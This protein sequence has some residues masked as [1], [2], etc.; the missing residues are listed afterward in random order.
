MFKSIEAMS[1]ED[2]QCDCSCCVWPQCR[3]VG[4]DRGGQSEPATEEMVGGPGHAPF[5]YC[6]ESYLFRC[7]LKQRYGFVVG[8]NNDTVDFVCFTFIIVLEIVNNKKRLKYYVFSSVYLAPSS[9]TETKCNETS[10]AKERLRGDV[11][12]IFS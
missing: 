10:L 9:A 6:F 2:I 4:D 1:E 8:F 11:Y 7:R 5:C 12:Q 3:G